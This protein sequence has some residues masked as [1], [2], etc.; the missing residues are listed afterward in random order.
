MNQGRK[1]SQQNNARVLLGISDIIES[2]DLQKQ[3]VVCIRRTAVQERAQ[4]VAEGETM[5]HRT[6]AQ[7][8]KKATLR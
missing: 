5:E 7:N 6:G 8:T 4:D 3:D 2:S 1:N